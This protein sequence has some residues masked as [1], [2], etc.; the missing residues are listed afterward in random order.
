MRELKFIY[1]NLFTTV[2]DL[3]K[4]IIFILL[5]VWIGFSAS[6]VYCTYFEKKEYSSS[7]T[8]SVNTSRNGVAA[9]SQ[10]VS[11]SIQLA[12]KV[13]DVI[14][15][16]TF[17]RV[18]AEKTGK[19]FT[20]RVYSVQYTD[21]NF[22]HVSCTCDDPNKAYEE[23]GIIL[24]NQEQLAEECFPGVIFSIVKNPHMDIIASHKFTDLVLEIEYSVFSGIFATLLI[25]ILS[26]FRDT[27][28][29]ESD[30][31]HL[32][33]SEAFGIVY[34]EK[35]DKKSDK[36]YFLFSDHTTSYLFNHSFSQMAIKLE[37]LKRTSDLK[38][39]LITSV[40][41]NEGKTT[42]SSN[43]ACALA[44]EGN[45]VAL[46]DIDFKRPT[47]HKRFKGFSSQENHDLAKYI[48]G[49]I[50]FDKTVQFDKESRVYLYGNKKSYKNSL[51]YL[52]S[53]KFLKFI[54]VL[55]EMYDFVIFDSAPCG[56]VSDSEMISE[57]V[58][59]V[60]LVVAQDY[61]EVDAIN[62]TIDNI[63]SE[64]ILGCVFNKVGAF[65]RSIKT[66]MQSFE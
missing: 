43:L 42:V 7:M 9:A 63:G 25:V 44:A 39:V 66:K 3:K 34:E 23:L 31:E 33:G 6:R 55:E 29:N 54:K 52:R 18:V 2:K 50:D 19:P 58:S 22:V 36:D 48:K 60:L 41:E 57:Y 47:I 45:K 51:E 35:Y 65:K 14:S 46:V 28:K 59:T 16:P 15:N 5:A 8:I 13:S 30:F 61:T 20:S 32:L 27:V 21:T 38:S 40:F 62:D 10:N 26:Y 49:D 4:N 56:L 24:D 12:N 53:E 37:S 11:D 1:F 17:L 64:K